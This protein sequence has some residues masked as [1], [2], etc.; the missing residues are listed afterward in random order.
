[1]ATFNEGVMSISGPIQHKRGTSAALAASG[2]VPAAGEIIIATDTGEIRSG[3]GV[4]TWSNLPSYD[5]TEIANNLTTATAGKAL[6]ASQGKALNDRVGT[7]ENITGI[8]CGVI[9]AD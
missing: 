5:G 2:Y 7:L 4:N 8:D 9:T 6:D 1:M 3:D